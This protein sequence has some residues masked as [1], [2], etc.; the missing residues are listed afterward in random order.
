MKKINL[1]V[2]V[3]SCLALIGCDPMYSIGFVI[4]NESDD[5]IYLNFRYDTVWDTLYISGQTDL[6]FD[7]EGGI[8][9]IE[10][11]LERAELNFDELVIENMDGEQFNKNAS[12]IETWEK[13]YSGRGSNATIEL[14][15]TNED[16]Q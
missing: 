13:N 5:R 16:F 2:V 3:I 12:D 15:V 6:T 11:E 7:G 10:N 1:F 9:I 8:G 4:H 14:F